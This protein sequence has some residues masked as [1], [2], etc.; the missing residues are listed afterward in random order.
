MSVKK[1]VKL[2]DQA[3]ATEDVVIDNVNGDSMSL[4]VNGIFTSLT[5]KVQGVD[6]NENTVYNDIAAIKMSDFSI[7]ET[8]TAAGLYEVSIDALAKIKVSITAISG[9]NVTVTAKIMA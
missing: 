4:A 1:F 2:F 7:C 9:G 5:L 6:D 3:T 8:I